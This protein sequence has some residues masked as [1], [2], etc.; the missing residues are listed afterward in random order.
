MKDDLQSGDNVGLIFFI[1][2]WTIMMFYF[3]WSKS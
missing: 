2:S 3:Y 1:I